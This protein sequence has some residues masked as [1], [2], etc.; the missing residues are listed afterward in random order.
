MKKSQDEKFY[1]RPLTMKQSHRH[2]LLWFAVGISCAIVF[3]IWITSFQSQLLQSGAT[4]SKTSSSDI[5]STLEA[6]RD[7]LESGIQKIPGFSEQTTNSS[8]STDTQATVSDTLPPAQVQVYEEAIFPD[9]VNLENVN[10]DDF[11][12][13]SNVQ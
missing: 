8:G 4:S 2:A 12:T 11:T 3:F 9:V 10:A 1:H 7:A 6:F 5:I 13:E